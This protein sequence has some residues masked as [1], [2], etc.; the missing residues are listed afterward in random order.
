DGEQCVYVDPQGRPVALGPRRDPVPGASLRLTIDMGLQETLT[1][2]LAGA[3][4]GVDGEPRGDLGCAVAMDPATGQVLAMAS[5]PSYDTNLYGPPVDAGA[6]ARAA[7]ARGHPMLEHA[8]QVVAP[9][10][11]AFKVVVAAADVANPVFAPGRA[12]PTGG[13]FTIGGH[14]FNN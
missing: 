6:L 1:A 12:I 13:S 4:R 7:A 5:V 8:T 2:A 14:R 9:P 11:S 3:L 10:G